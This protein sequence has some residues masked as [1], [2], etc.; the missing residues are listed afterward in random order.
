MPSSNI[1][2]ATVKRL[3]ALFLTVA[4]CHASVGQTT[5]NILDV[6]NRDGALDLSA[7]NISDVNAPGTW[8]V[9]SG[10]TVFNTTNVNGGALR[11]TGAGYAWLNFAPQDGF[12]YTISLTTTIAPGAGDRW[13]AIG[14][15]NGLQSVPYN[16][17]GP[18]MLVKATGSF[19]S[20]YNGVNNAI[21]S[22]A[23]GSVNVAGTSNL[24]QI[25][26]D[27]TTSGSWK[28][29][30]RIN[31]VNRGTPATLPFWSITR[32]MISDFGTINAT[33]TG[34]S[35]TSIQPAAPTISSQPA[36][37][38]NWAGANASL[39]VAASGSQPLSYQWYKGDFNNPVGGQTSDT[40]LFQPL[41]GTDSGSYF[42]IVANSFGS[43]TS[44]VAVVHAEAGGM[45]TLTPAI[46]VGALPSVNSDAA[47]GLNSAN[48]YVAAINF[49]TGVDPVSV[50]GV[51][52][53]A[54]N[55][56]GMAATNGIHS[57]YGGN[58][59]LSKDTIF[60][61]QF[62]AEAGSAFQVDGSM[63]MLLNDAVTL[64]GSIVVDDAMTVTFGT[65]PT[66]TYSLLVYFR[67]WGDGLPLRANFIFNGRGSNEVVELNENIGATANSAGAYYVRY[68]FTA[69]TNSVSVSLAGQDANRAVRL[70]AAALQQVSAP[71]VPPGISTQPHGFT[72]W[73]GF[74]GSLNVSA[75]GTVPL[76]Y[77]WYQGNV[78][79]TGETNTILG[80][81]SLIG[82]NSG[83]YTVVVTNLG[84]A[85]TSSVA[86]VFVVA[87]G[88]WAYTPSL[89]VVQ[90]PTT[91]SDAASGI[92]STN[93]Y[94]AALDFGD[95]TS[96]LV[97]NGVN[98]TQVS[99]AGNGTGTANQPVF[100]GVDANYG[101]SWSLTA[102]N[103]AGDAAGF[104]GLATDAA[105]NVG[106]QADG[107]M[108]LMLTDIS[109]LFGA[110]PPGNFARLTMG[111]LTPG[112]RYSLRY[113]YRQWSAN[114]PIDF[115]FDGQGTN[116]TVQVDLDAGGAN[117]VN[118]N[119]IAART[120]VTL[121]LGVNVTQQ[122]PHFYGVTLQQTGSATAPALHIVR[123]GS[124]VTI[125]W[126]T[127]ISGFTLESTTSLTGGN[128]TAV[129]GVTTNGIT[130][131]NPTG[132]MFYRLRN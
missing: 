113:Y 42:A 5:T 103:T 72:N 116:E 15:D 39:A 11:I 79:L 87:N 31:G 52:F 130:V 6:F 106:L 71:L 127:A 3:A 44:A 34:F 10:A 32:V 14:F 63:Q 83:A 28:A 102:S 7:P 43:I 8:S 121:T 122:G 74:S 23:A 92:A 107:N 62:S 73:A 49:G 125:W 19:E 13:V 67:D 30:I 17:N 54:V 124:Q 126:D 94:L 104:A 1:S 25:V 86:N 9:P 105:G 60:G 132:N 85:I 50:N 35:V 101:G 91:G 99:V 46:S 12:V 64:T 22:G 129:P 95:D 48:T 81:Q 26:L 45:M 68:N 66:G 21:A 16:A 53:D 27:T 20:Y 90:I 84:G 118:Y 78:P 51:L 108:Q 70:Y 56:T 36:G 110:V 75:T 59:S 82:A 123:S 69:A 65:V 76:R 114:R 93:T 77:Q 97:I 98:F 88:V 38:T 115:T 128:W 111:G 37:I 120:N 112:A 58:W 29:Q 47:S 55:P 96:A 117:Y 61:T 4:W 80:F 33:N 89:S 41:A 40:L 109:Y 24:L 131:A 100:S 2:C 119:F 18:W 57:S